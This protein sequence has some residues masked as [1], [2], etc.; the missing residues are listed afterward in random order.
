MRTDL[1]QIMQ[2]IIYHKNQQ[3]AIDGVKKIQYNK[4]IIINRMILLDF[5]YKKLKIAF[6]AFVLSLTV[7]S[8]SFM[9][10]CN[11]LQEYLQNSSSQ[12]ETTVAETE[13]K[14]TAPEKNTDKVLYGY[15][16][17]DDE[18]TR[19]LYG[20]IDKYANEDESV[21][22]HMD[23]LM[24]TREIYEAI[25]AY[26]DDHPE[27]FWLKNYKSFSYVNGTYY[28]SLDFTVEGD[29][30][31]AAKQKFDSTVEKIVN[32]APKNASEFELEVYVNDYIVDNCEYDFDYA[33][34]DEN[35]GNAGSAY[36]VLVEGKAICEGYARAFNL[37]CSRLGLESANIYGKG[38]KESHIW[39]CIKIDGEWYQIDVTWND[40]DSEEENIS[41]YFYFNLTDEQ[42]YADHTAGELFKNITNDEYIE[43]NY[44]ANLFV[45]ECTSTEYNYFIQK[46]VVVSDINDDDEVAEAI[47]E[48][49]H[50]GDDYFYI[51]ID[52]SLDFDYAAEQII[53]EGYLASW[54]GSAN[55]KNFYSPC[56]NVEAVVYKV[57]ERKVL[58]TVL[59]YS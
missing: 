41:R 30:K 47:A 7:F 16:N 26:K 12:T 6:I 46:G 36:G 13:P 9:S 14:P 48:A 29:E 5:Q 45:P 33:E 4:N 19:I 24:S 44:N 25:Y 34:S 58:I 56:L 3:N 54:I 11:I 28:F 32:G 8:I 18:T 53:Y 55:L 52:D 59:E 43:L 35:E 40:P 57:Y 42:M 2:K 51:L 38:D 23:A 17:L 31:E 49:A 10:G 22:F 20:L 1:A 39:N 21:S 27:V 50:N 15:D 37:L